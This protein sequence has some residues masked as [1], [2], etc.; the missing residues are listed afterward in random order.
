MTNLNLESALWFGP[1]E[2]I[3]PTRSLLSENEIWV[4][5]AG[6]ADKLSN[7]NDYVDCVNE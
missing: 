4:G 6:S 2:L 3:V 1:I 7:R 5:S